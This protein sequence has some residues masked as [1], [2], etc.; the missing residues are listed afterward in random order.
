MTTTTLRRIRA[1]H[2]CATSWRRLLDAVGGGQA[3]GLDTPLPLTRVLDVLGLA[4]AIWACRRLPAAD[5]PRLAEFARRVA[6]RVEHLRS[7]ASVARAAYTDRVAHVAAYR[8]VTAADAAA[9]AARAAVSAS[10]AAAR[11]SRAAARAAAAETAAD[12]ATEAARSAAAAT[13]EAAA[14][15]TEAAR[16]AAARAAAARAAAAAAWH[17]E[18]AVQAAIFREIFG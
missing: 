15:A 16:S 11:A 13:A 4:D 9:T 1:C 17:A 2:L 5:L 14:A 6:Q 18:R 8:A 7:T 10:V 3:Y 12:A